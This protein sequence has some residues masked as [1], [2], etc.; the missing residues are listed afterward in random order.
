MAGSAGLSFEAGLAFEH[1]VF[2]ELR[3]SAQATALRHIFFA[4]RR[5]AK[6]PG[7]GSA[8]PIQCIGVIG[9]GTMGAGIAAACLLAG[10]RVVLVER[11]E[12]ALGAGRDRLAELL[13]E[14]ERRGKLSADLHADI[15]ADR[16]VVAVEMAALAEADLVVE[17]VFESMEVKQDVFRTLDRVA[18]PGA[19]LATNTSYLDVAR[20]SRP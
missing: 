5:I 12:A 10:L 6:V 7:L 13:A 15:V 3:G 9:G 19:V 8:R 4:E 1:T 20:R 14:A 11:D 18:K 16:L 17:A 2:E